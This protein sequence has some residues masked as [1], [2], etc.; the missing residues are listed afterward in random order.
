VKFINLIGVKPG[1]D[2]ELVG[3]SGSEQGHARK[4][5]MAYSKLAITDVQQGYNKN[6]H[7]L[8]TSTLW[9]AALLVLPKES[10]EA[11]R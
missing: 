7:H 4:S 2:A 10:I 6:N 11:V 9:G 1:R 3:R 8:I 5:L